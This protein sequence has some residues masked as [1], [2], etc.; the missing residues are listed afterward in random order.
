MDLGDALRVTAEAAGFAGFGVCEAAPFTEAAVSIADANESGRA[1]GLHFTY[2]N[3]AATDITRSFPWARRLVVGAWSYLEQAGSPGPPSAGSGRVA[4]FATEDHYSDLRRGLTDIADLLGADGHRAEILIDDNRLVD[5][6]AA[7]RAGVGWWGKNTMVLTPGVGPWILLGSVVTDA[8]LDVSEPMRRDC[9]SCDACLPACPTGALVAPGVLDARR[10]LAYWAQAPGP[11]PPELRTAM[12]DRVYGCDDCIE[13]CP[14]GHRALAQ[15]SGRRAGRLELLQLLGGDAR[16]LLQ[17]FSHFYVP[18]RNPRFLR[19]NALVALGNVG[20]A[21]AVAVAAGFLGH[22]DALLRTHAA[23]ALGSLGGPMARAALTAR[24][25][26]ERDAG[27]V[28]EI[29]EALAKV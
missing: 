1:A 28:G 10:C 25:A 13:A 3:P 8:L 21:E 16:S 26:N 7:A 6:A 14:P 17:R 4:R 11:I 18:K 24:A 27:V 29:S 22:P 20:G 19:R 2:T 15:H 12:G 23:W 5:R 9:G